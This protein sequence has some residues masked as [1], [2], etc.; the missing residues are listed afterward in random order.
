VDLEG[1]TIGARIRSGRWTE[2]EARSKG[3]CISK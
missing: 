1:D 3:N 2:E